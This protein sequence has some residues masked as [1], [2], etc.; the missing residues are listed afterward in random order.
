M[1]ER[2]KIGIIISSTRPGRFADT[3]T[4][5]LFNIAKQRDDADF[6][7][8]DLRHYPMP[9][10]EEKVALAYAPTQ[11]PTA[12]RWQKKIA[13]LDG[14]IFVTAEYNHS[15][16]GVL[17]NALDYLYSEIHRKPATFVGYGGTGGARAVEHLRNILA[18]E[19]VASLKHTVHI[20]MVEML[21][22]LRE[23]KSM[24]DY[25]FLDDFAKRMLDDL[26]WWANT[27]KEG[28]FRGE[29]AEAAEAVEAA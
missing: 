22:M 14:Y 24:A 17:K 5:W 10:F 6:E 18:E 21:G 2:P 12:L 13:S 25:P 26:V 11:N 1:Q 9:F 29:A 19:Q 28:R 16:P 20:G 8:V 27:L 15:I 3:P 4:D 7:I 23:G